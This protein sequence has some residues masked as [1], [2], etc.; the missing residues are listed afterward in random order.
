MNNKNIKVSIIIV[1]Y[2]V[3][4]ELLSCLSSIY[5]S[6]TKLFYEVIVIDNDKVGIINEDLKKK[7]PKVVYIK[8]HNNI[9][10]GAGNNLG[11]KSARGEILFF[12]NPDTTV[13]KGSIDILYDFIINN[14]KAGMVAP[15]LFDPAGNVYPCQGSDA[16][17][18]ISAIVVL[19]F[20]NKFFPDNPVSAKFSH[21]NWDKKHVEEFDVVPGTAFMIKRSIFEKAGMFDEEFFLY[22]EE[23]DLAKRV[24]KLG[25]KNYIIPKSKIFHIWE[26]STKKRKDI[27]RIFAKSRYIFFK[28]HY[29]SL[30]ALI[31]NI[32]SNF[33]KYEFILI[34]TLGLS[35]FLGLFKIREL[36]TFIGDQ[37]WF[38]L[39]ARDLISNGEMP[40]V[41]IASSRPWLHQGPLWTYFLT[42]FLLIFNFDPVSGAYLSMILGLFT[43]IGLYV[44]G[45]KIF[46]KRVGLIASLL[47]AVSPFVVFNIRMPYHTSPIPLFVVVLIFSLYK[48]AQNKIIYLP[49][50]ILLLSILYNLEIATVILWFVVMGLVSYKLFKNEISFKEIWNK[51]IL[52][53]SIISL[54]TPLLPMILYDVRNGFPQTL[55]FA[56]WVFYRIASFF[57]YNPEHMFDFKKIIIMFDFLFINFTKLIFPQSKLISFIILISLFAWAIYIFLKRRVGMSLYSLVIL[58]FLG[59]LLLIILNQT[60]SDA[61]LSILFP[62]IFLLIALFFDYMMQFKKMLVPII[63]VLTIIVFG[64]TYFMLKN[65]FTFNPESHFFSLEKRLNISKEILNIIGD[66]DYNLK[67]QGSGSEHE[68]FTMNYEYLAWWLGHGPSRKEEDMGVYVSE[69]PTGIKIDKFMTSYYYD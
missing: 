56:I 66:K 55:K 67:G 36:M 33:G 53:M 27:D 22:F 51:K 17:T 59:P 14:P 60:P 20:L 23:Y 3:K 40:L 15:L 24:K 47:Y 28:K 1:N 5:K 57:G 31:I 64:N 39:S 29:G 26:A 19:S 68:S 34:L 46:S 69:S 21:R 38:Y 35:V 50:T 44:V 54:I 42:P 62:I 13:A 43:I 63:F 25:Y 37:A 16:Y 9:G 58:L 6:D 4:D 49:L 30:F 45:S 65:N 10:Y 18:L 52:T 32:V 2:K 8:S 12:L 48:I 41:G 61:Y 11:T 7:F